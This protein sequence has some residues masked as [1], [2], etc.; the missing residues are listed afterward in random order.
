MMGDPHKFGHAQ[1]YATDPRQD[2]AQGVIGNAFH[3]GEYQTHVLLGGGGAHSRVNNCRAP[4]KIQTFRASF[5]ILACL[6]RYAPCL[7]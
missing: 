7:I 2:V 1:V 4:L 5:L 3:G 6:H